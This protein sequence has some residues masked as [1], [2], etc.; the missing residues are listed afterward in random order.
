MR[1]RKRRFLDEEDARRG[2][3]SA[4]LK[5]RYFGPGLN[6][7]SVTIFG[8]IALEVVYVLMAVV[9]HPQIFFAVAALAGVAWTISASE[10]CVAGSTSYSR[11][12][13]EVG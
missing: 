11:L 6:G 9:R 5:R 8:G 10:L 7:R 2:F 3:D 4:I 12:E 13:S 1:D